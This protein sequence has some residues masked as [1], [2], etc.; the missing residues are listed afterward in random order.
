[1]Q[2]QTTFCY[3]LIYFAIGFMLDKPIAEPSK[4][5]LGSLKEGIFPINC[6]ALTGSLAKGSKPSFV[7]FLYIISL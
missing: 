4:F 6:T 5:R 7:F 1:M 3:I 2:T